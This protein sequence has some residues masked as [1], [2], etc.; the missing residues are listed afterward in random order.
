MKRSL[1]QRYEDTIT[2]VQAW[3]RWRHA[4]GYQDMCRINA[5]RLTDLRNARAADLFTPISVMQ[6]LD[7]QILLNQ[8]GVFTYLAQPG[9]V[10]L[11]ED[12]PFSGDPIEHRAIVCAIVSD[13]H[14]DWLEGQLWRRGHL[15]HS[16]IRVE[17]PAAQYA[18]AI[19][20]LHDPDDRT[21]YGPVGP[22]AVNGLP[23]TRIN[24]LVKGAEI[25]GR[26]GGQM[27]AAEIHWLFP[28]RPD[29]AAQLYRGWQYSIYAENFGY[30]D[31]FLT[32]AEICRD[33]LK[34]R[35]TMTAI[36]NELSEQ[37]D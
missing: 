34:L 31:L 29:A 25:V 15:E 4:T 12:D 21:K 2:R 23:V 3:R 1:I 36:T 13:E 7:A 18:Q 6:M 8:C 17:D 5:E 9:G 19:L 20:E 32:L 10:D 27:T 14:K 11:R 16:R 24:R 22:D 30:S 37:Q 26:A 35:G 33:E 28:V